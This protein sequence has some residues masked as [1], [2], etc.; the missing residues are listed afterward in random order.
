[1]MATAARHANAGW[2]LFRVPVIHGIADK[3][4]GTGEG[5]DT[6]LLGS[7]WSLPPT[8]RPKHQALA[9]LPSLYCEH[10]ARD[11]SVQRDKGNFVALCGDVDYG[12]HPID[13]IEQAVRARLG[14]V[15]Y[16]I[17]STANAVEGDMR[18][19]VVVP[20]AR[21][22][23]FADW[24][25]A[26]EAFS[27][28]LRGDGIELDGV[29]ARA[30]QIMYL[31]N[32]PTVHHDTG[33]P[34]RDESGPLYYATR[35]TNTDVP[36]LWL[37]A[38]SLA[39][40]I[41]DLRCRHTEDER[42][43]EKLRT[44]AAQRRANQ[45]QTKDG[46]VID[47]FNRSNTV[48]DM[49]AHCGYTQSPR[50]PND[51][52]SPH[53]TSGSYATRDMGHHWV[54]LSESDRAAGV[55]PTCPSGCYGDSYDLSVHWEYQ[56]NRSTAWS[57]AC[58][59]Q[60]RERPSDRD[61]SLAQSSPYPVGD[62]GWAEERDYGQIEDIILSVAA[63]LMD[64]PPLKKTYLDTSYGNDF[65]SI[66]ERLKHGFR[67]GIQFLRSEAILNEQ[68]LPTEVA[69][70]LVCALWADVPEHDFDKGGNA[71]SLIRKAL[72]RASYLLIKSPPA[73][74]KSRALMFIALDKL[75]NQD[76]KQAIIVVPEKSIGGSFADEPLSQYGFWADWAVKPQWNLCNAPGPDEEKVDQSKV[77]AVGQF[78]S[79]DDN[80]LVCTHATFRFAVDAL[81]VE[82]FDDRLIAV[83]EFHHVSAHPDN[84]LGAHLAAFLARDKAH[85]VAMT[86]SYGP[87]G[88]QEG[89]TNVGV[90]E[91]TGQLHF[92]IAGLVEPKSAEASRIVQED[93]N[94]VIAAFVQNKTV[95]ERGMFDEETG[96][97]SG[98]GRGGS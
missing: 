67:H 92:E 90:R 71:R 91:G 56:G 85:I 70:Y 22:A 10:D 44:Q 81:G 86:G 54:S 41:A 60:G 62:P 26:E 69:V 49:L 55:G 9:F 48:A 20:L 76:L 47:A 28:I 42:L 32:V 98:G 78:L 36:G 75:A 14:N 96:G 4:I 72:W 61:H 74:G 52:R 84:R 53:Q 17:Y 3:R 89:K 64:R 43:R 40:A 5:F 94:E 6:R 46:S 97:R 37:D 30:G 88:Y 68:C 73:S 65:A 87:D 51:W 83:D 95:A 29:T 23:A 21:P 34:L 2:Q 11:H 12:N 93:L 19:R 16:N 8:S 45:P 13:H 27:E 38:G 59:E 25:D 50:N 80:V 79:S 39:D 15:A 58:R 1:M 77:K 31:P 33:Q 7:L 24:R 57:A 82:A 66:W 18:W 35:T 63:L